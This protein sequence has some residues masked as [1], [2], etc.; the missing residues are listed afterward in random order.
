MFRLLSLAAITSLLLVSVQSISATSSGGDITFEYH[1]FTSCQEFEN[2]LKQVLPTTYQQNDYYKWGGML[3]EQWTVT[4][5]APTASREGNIPKSDTN[6][7]VRGIDEADM[8]KTDGKYVYTFQEWEHAIVILDAKTLT[9]VKTLRIPIHYSG[10]NFYVTKNKLILTA[11]KTIGYQHYWTYWYNNTQKSIIALYDI[12]DMSRTSLVRS[13]EVDG[14]LSDTRLGDTGIMTAVVATSYWMPP[15][16]RYDGGGFSTKMVPRPQYNYNSK[17]LIPRISDQ[18]FSAWKRTISNRGIGDCSGMSSILPKT[19]TLSQ[20]TINPTLTSIL[21]FDTSIPDGQITSQ[22]ILSEAGQIHVTRDSVYLTANMWQQ[23]PNS[24]CPPNARCIMPMIWNPGTSSTLVHRFSATNAS[25]RYSYSTLI[26]GSPLN[27]YSMDENTNGDFRIVT[28]V[29]S[30]S[31]GLNT[32]TTNLSII[33][34]AGT[35]IGRLSGIAPGEN[36]QSSRFIGNRLYLVTFE[37]IDPLFVIDTTDSKNPKIL[38]ELL[39]PWYSTYLHPYDANRLIGIGY[40]TFTNS[41]GGTQNGGIKI[42]LYNVSDIANPKREATLTLGD[43]WSSS[44][45]LWNPKAFVWYKEKNLLLI[46]ATLMTTAGNKDNIYL[47][48][49]AF[50]WLLGISITPSSIQEK[51][52]VTHIVPPVTLTE[53]WKKDCAQ[54]TQS[55]KWYQLYIPEYCKPNATI[56][57]YM[58]NTIW[59]Y[60]SDFISRVL[61]V[62]DNLYTIGNSRIQLQT[63]TNPTTP[64]AT[65]KFKTRSYS[66]YP[67]PWNIIT[68]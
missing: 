8:V 40:D 19:N 16:Y 2:T 33:N 52:R 55:N 37:Q 13:I 57:M 10:V 43:A 27:Q 36:F 61:Y 51:F 5:I 56:D 4:A 34:S 29:S 30:W 65:Q 53:T 58:A 47:S 54:Y 1:T 45:V 59:N 3:F 38:G 28:T 46:P 17:D 6:V 44:D 41:H 9:R 23:N 50:Q 31:G 32:S 48:K 49:S 60:S 42:D 14:S 62:G 24:A 63:F 11:T 20:F 12:R 22:V 25:I 39:M 15:I 67:V 68:Q 64:V 66:G 21:R 18:Q 7:Q 35:K 26:A